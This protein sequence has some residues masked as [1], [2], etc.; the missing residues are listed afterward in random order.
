MFK[1]AH[2]SDV[3]LGPLPDMTYRELISKRVTGWYNWQRNRR[4][5]IH[6]GV[7]D[8]ILDDIEAAAPDHIAVSGDLV[9]LALDEEIE[10][11]RKWLVDLGQPDRV[12]AVPGNHDAYVP[13]A[14]DRACRSWAP[15]MTGDNAGPP[16]GNDEFPYLRVRAAVALVGV[17]SA[18]ATAPFMANGFFR[19][20]QAERAAKMLDDTRDRGL[21]R[22]L[23]I[24]HPPV[25]GAALQHKRLFGIGR[26]QDMVRDHGADLVLHGHTHLPT[27]NWMPGQGKP[28]PVVGVAAAGEAHGEEKPLAQWNLIEIDGAAKDWTVRLTRRGLSERDGK[29]GQISSQMLRDGVAVKV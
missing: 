28:V 1:L 2:L 15:F 23:M 13:G 24:H 17:T 20:G 26:F 8:A 21:F 18:R 19:E 10:A 25:R 6:G 14:F 3:H 16:R 7:I 4:K 22:V 5:H 12:S 27:L 11:A 29:V 9:N